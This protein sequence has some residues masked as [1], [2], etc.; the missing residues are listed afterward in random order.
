MHKSCVGIL[1]LN[2]M[3]CSKRAHISKFE[4]MVD[5]ENSHGKDMVRS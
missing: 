2:C 4:L 3:S 5:S 1:N